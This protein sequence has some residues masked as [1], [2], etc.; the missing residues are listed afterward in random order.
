MYIDCAAT[1]FDAYLAAT[2]AE[3]AV[4]VVFIVTSVLRFLS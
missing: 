3:N 1:E 4:V 2:R